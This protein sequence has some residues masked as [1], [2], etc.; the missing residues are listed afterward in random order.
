MVV[1]DC[2]WVPDCSED[3]VELWPLWPLW[4][5]MPELPDWPL[6]LDWPLAPVLWSPLEPELPDCPPLLDCASATAPLSARAN[7]RV[8]NLVIELLVVGVY[9]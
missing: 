9:R 6:V 4:P 7:I 1:P 3:V 2:D 8:N 5:L